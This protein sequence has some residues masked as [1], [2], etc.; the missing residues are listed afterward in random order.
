MERKQMV[1]NIADAVPHV[2]VIATL[3]GWL[4]PIAAAFSIVWIGLQIA[5]KVTGK[6]FHLLSA[7]VCEWLAALCKRKWF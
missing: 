1:Q 3:A 6:P 7:P 5:E 2:G 4:P